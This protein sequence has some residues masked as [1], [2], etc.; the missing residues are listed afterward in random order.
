MI[1]C[2]RGNIASQ[3]DMDAIVNAANAELRIDGGVA[4]AIHRVAGPGFG[5]GVP[6][7]RNN[8]SRP[9]SWNKI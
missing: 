3:P 9:A 7:V 8:P 2:V 5:S 1:E 6:T 4:D